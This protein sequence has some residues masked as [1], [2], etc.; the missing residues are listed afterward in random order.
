MFV[1]N[2]F[3]VGS[4]F[5]FWV[6]VFFHVLVGALTVFHSIKGTLSLSVVFPLLIVFI[7]VFPFFYLYALRKLLLELQNRERIHVGKDA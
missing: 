5:R 6:A 2:A 3:V 4:K 1:R 7:V